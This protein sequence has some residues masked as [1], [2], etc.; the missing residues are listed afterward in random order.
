MSI[1]ER[2]ILN[3]LEKIFEGT[4]YW[5]PISEKNYLTTKKQLNIEINFMKKN[6]NGW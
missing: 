5:K 6:K 4:W 1:I 3:G 2:T